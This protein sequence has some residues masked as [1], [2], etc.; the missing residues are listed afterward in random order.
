MIRDEIYGRVQDGG[1]NP[2]FYK[3]ML[4]KEWD[5]SLNVEGN[6]FYPLI[7]NGTVMD[8]NFTM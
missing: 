5:G 1:P 6:A 2:R 7:K 8:R 4:V 3:D